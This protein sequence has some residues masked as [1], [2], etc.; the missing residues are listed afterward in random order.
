MSRRVAYALDRLGGKDLDAASVATALTEWTSVCHAPPARLRGENNDLNEFV[1]PFARRELERA[2]RVLPRHLAREL[3]SR[4]TPL[5]E[6][7]SA[8]TLPEPA[9]RTGNWWDER[10]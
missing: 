9:R 2:L 7:Y 10:R 6:L 4:V 8:K 1:G 5:D 3:R